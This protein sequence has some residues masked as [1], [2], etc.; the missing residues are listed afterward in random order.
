MGCEKGVEFY[1]SVY[2][3]DPKYSEHY[4]NLSYYPV[5]QVVNGMLGDIENPSILEVG[6]GTGQFANV[7]WDRNIK[8]Y[9]GID[10]SEKAI[11]IA[12]TMS[13]QA[14][15]VADIRSYAI[16][17]NFNTVIFMEVLEHIT[18]DISVIEKVPLETNTIITLPRFDDPGHVR[19]FKT[20]DSIVNRYGSLIRIDEI[21][22]Y[23]NWYIVKGVRSGSHNNHSC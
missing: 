5:F 13:P 9:L 19:I 6:C 22:R 10:F 16:P 14:F 21:I 15:C 18:D 8:D 1:D 4:K 3:R 23:V 12:K 2:E 7:L 11:S 17:N 20:R